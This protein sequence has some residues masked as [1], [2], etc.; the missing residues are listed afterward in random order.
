MVMHAC[1]WIGDA[2]CPSVG[3]RIWIDEVIFDVLG[4]PHSPATAA[5]GRPTGRLTLAPAPAATGRL[6]AAR[7]AAAHWKTYAAHEH[8][9]LKA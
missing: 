1:D 5:T 2:P 8:A 9:R 3:L 6:S 7:I 4:D